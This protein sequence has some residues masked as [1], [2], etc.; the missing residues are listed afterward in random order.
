MVET[1]RPLPDAI[2]EDDCESIDGT[3]EMVHLNLRPELRGRI[4]SIVVREFEGVDHL[5]D[6]VAELAG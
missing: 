5:P 3:I 2:I 6:T 4:K 1:I